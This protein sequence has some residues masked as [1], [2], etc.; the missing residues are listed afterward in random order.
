VLHPGQIG[1]VNEAFSPGQDD[2]ERAELILDAYRYY[3]EVEH[4]EAAMLGDEMIDEA[5]RQLALVTAAKGRAAGLARSQRFEPGSAGPGAPRSAE[6]SP[7]G[8]GLGQPGGQG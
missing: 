4:R 6:D 1:I 5:S 8:E 2:Y 7:G 3:T